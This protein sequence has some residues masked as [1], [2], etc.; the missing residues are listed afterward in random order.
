MLKHTAIVTLVVAATIASAAAQTKKPAATNAVTYDVT[1]QAD[2]P[3]TGTMDLAVKG[4]VVSGGMRIATPTEITGNVAGTSKAGEMRLDFPYEM[5]T[6][7]CTGQ[8]KMTIAA[9]AKPAPTKGTVS[10]VGCG[11]DAAAPLSGT[12][13]LKPAVKK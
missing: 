8:I 3:Y 6:R 11:R 5:V 12:I 2:G 1:I 10:I 9:P 4:G 7:K 13:E